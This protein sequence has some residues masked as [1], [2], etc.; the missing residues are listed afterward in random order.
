MILTCSITTLLGAYFITNLQK[1]SKTSKTNFIYLEELQFRVSVLISNVI[2]KLDQIKFSNRIIS[3]E[4]KRKKKRNE[5]S[6]AI[7][8]VQ[9][10]TNLK[11][12]N[13]QSSYFISG[14]SLFSWKYVKMNWVNIKKIIKNL[15][16][17]IYCLTNIFTENFN[18]T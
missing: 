11:I 1:I 13:L 5:S 10:N 2:F 4:K 8:S 12:L 7:I 6:Y 18:F 16:R 15:V 9:I 17:S 14:Q 3:L